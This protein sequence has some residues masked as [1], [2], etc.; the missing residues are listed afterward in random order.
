M[1]GE[2]LFLDSGLG[3][4]EEIMS[5]CSVGRTQAERQSE[6]HDRDAR[7]LFMR[8]RSEQA[9]KDNFCGTLRRLTKSLDFSP[10]FKQNYK[11]P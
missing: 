7:F 3:K 4:I 8:N 10:A 5:P 6:H 11:K 9:E 1:R 2:P